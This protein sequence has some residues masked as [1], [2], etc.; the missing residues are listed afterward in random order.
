MSAGFQPFCCLGG[1]NG[2]AAQEC[3]ARLARWLA[4]GNR[5]ERAI[6]EIKSLLQADELATAR[7]RHPFPVMKYS[8]GEL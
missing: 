2:V 8:Q 5:A 6:P 1:G 3:G 7:H 4:P